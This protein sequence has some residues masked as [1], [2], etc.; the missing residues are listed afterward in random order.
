[1]RKQT[2]QDKIEQMIRDA[3]TRKFGSY[4]SAVSLALQFAS[5]AHG[6]KEVER[7]QACIDLAVGLI[8]EEVSK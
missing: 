8:K 1:M 4:N 6:C 3:V 2:K 7:Q 5:Q